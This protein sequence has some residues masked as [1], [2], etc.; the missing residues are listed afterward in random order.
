MT[1]AEVQNYLQMR[2]KGFSAQLKQGGQKV[3]VLGLVNVVYAKVIDAY[4]KG[5]LVEVEDLQ[6]WKGKTPQPL[7]VK[8]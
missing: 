1:P 8:K 7:T 2:P 5:K 3:H 6:R 4:G